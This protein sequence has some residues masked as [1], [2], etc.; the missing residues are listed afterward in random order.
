MNRIGIVKMR[1]N[2]LVDALRSGQPSVGSWLSLCSPVAAET[3]A[4]I[5]WDWLL[6]DV[7]HSL[8]GFETMVNCFRA[9]Q[10]GG[11]APLA[12]VPWNAVSYTHL[13]LPTKRIV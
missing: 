12:R 13:T 4:A 11:A 7:E 9:I 5:G 2:P 8:V 1:T 6:V 10:L 3:M